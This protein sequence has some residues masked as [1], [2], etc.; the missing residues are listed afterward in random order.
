MPQNHNYRLD[1][2]GLRA[3]AVIAVILF[4]AN[5]A[6]LPS[7]FLGVDVFF[8]I[9]GFLITGII[10]REMQNGLPLYKDDDHFNPYGARF[11]AEKFIED[12]QRLIQD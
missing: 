6:W 2:D 5:A 9:S 4:H 11:L 12:G 8:V 7:G 1:I 3:L 10:Q